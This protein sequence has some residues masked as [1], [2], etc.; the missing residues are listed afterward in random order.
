MQTK[1]KILV[2]R[3][4]A[5]G[6]VILTTPIVKKIYM[7]H[8]GFCDISIKTHWIDVF[9][10]NPYI[11]Q[12]LTS[13]ENISISEFD[14][15]INLDLAYEKNPSMHV[16][17]AYGMYAFGNNTFNRQCEIYTSISDKELARHIHA[18][19]SDGYLTVH[20][21][22]THQ[23]NRNI[24]QYFWSELIEKIIN[25]TSYHI[26]QIGTSSDF[27]FGG[28][29][30][31]VDM[32]GKLSLHELREVIERSA[33]YLGVDSAPIHI[34]GTT[35]TNIIGFYTTARYEYREP[36]RYKGAFTALIPKIDCYGCQVNLPLGSTIAAC[37]RGDNDCVNQFSTTDAISA[38][39][40]M[41][42]LNQKKDIK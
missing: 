29:E 40:H 38:L 30:R 41:T 18:T 2:N 11:Q 3:T 35:T 4:G 1:P 21:R 22:N 14:K 34:A 32:R 9:K 10:N 24:P 17:D 8:N 23:P 7:D 12:C 20:M 42:Y 37:A 36:I 13:D 33:C 31:L 6:D 19:H 15:F 16:I 39:Q 25:T 5:L 27:A 28:N 26:I